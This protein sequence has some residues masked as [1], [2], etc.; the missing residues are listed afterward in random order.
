MLGENSWSPQVSLQTMC[1]CIT[2][3]FHS[4]PAVTLFLGLFM[5]SA[6]RESF[7][8]N[9]TVHSSHLVFLPLKCFWS[10]NS[11]GSQFFFSPLH[12]RIIIYTQFSWSLHLSVQL[13]KALLLDFFF[14]SSTG[15]EHSGSFLCSGLNKGEKVQFFRCLL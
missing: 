6:V 14:F 7:V 9:S 1:H 2:N 3:L 8:L 11:D 5:G 4:L 15:K 10:L 13:R 12:K